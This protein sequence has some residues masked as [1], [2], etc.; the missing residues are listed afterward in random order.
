MLTA[1][2]GLHTPT[3]LWSLEDAWVNEWAPYSVACAVVLAAAMTVILLM[4]LGRQVAANTTAAA[5]TRRPVRRI[6]SPPEQPS[7]QMLA[8]LYESL[9]KVQRSKGSKRVEWQPLND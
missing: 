8:V 2:V 5:L 4:I 1:E 3:R 7:S 6:R 9:A